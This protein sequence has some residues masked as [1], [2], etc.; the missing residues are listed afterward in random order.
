VAAN[1]VRSTPSRATLPLVRSTDRRRIQH[2][3][4]RLDREVVHHRPVGADVAVDFARREDARQR[5]GGEDRVAHGRV[6]ETGQ[7]PEH[8]PARV[9][10]HGRDQQPAGQVAE[11]ALPDQL[12]DDPLQRLAPVDGGREHPL[13]GHV[14]VGDPEDVGAGQGEG[15]VLQLADRP[16]RRPRPGDQRPH[17]DADD[18]RGWSPPRAP[19]SPDVGQI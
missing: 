12:R 9:E 19:G 18:Q 16:A 15:P 14:Q 7:P 6:I 2:R 1:P 10:V 3:D 5:A 17:A 11:P 4:R 13:Q 8:L